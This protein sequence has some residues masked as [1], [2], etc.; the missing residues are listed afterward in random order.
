MKR[1][2]TIIG[3]LLI[4]S[5]PVTVLLYVPACNDKPT[6][7]PP[8][9][10][11]KD[12]VVWFYDANTQ[13]GVYGVHTLTGAI[14]SFT[15]PINPHYGLDVSADGTRL[16]VGD[17]N[18][19]Y[20]IDLDST[21]HTEVIPY[22]APH[23]ICVSPDGSL[24]ALLGNDVYILD[25][26]DNSPLF[27]DTSR[28][29]DG[30]FAVDSNILYCVTDPAEILRLNADDGFSISRSPVP[31][32]GTYQVVPCHSESKL[33]Y[34]SIISDCYYRIDGF[35]L[36]GDSMSF[37]TNV[38]PGWGMLDITKDGRYLVYTNSGWWLTY[39]W[40]PPMELTF[41]DIAADSIARRISTTGFVDGS[42]PQYWSAANFALTPDGRWL[43][44]ADWR[45]SLL[46]MLNLN[47][48]KIERYY[49]LGASRFIR[50]LRTQSA[51]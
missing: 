26:A 34:Y 12:Y 37:G 49:D 10:P 48:F 27:Y 2:M 8:P 29:T 40:D 33:Y 22:P 1:L 18:S 35:D 46:I 28:A 20:A 45:D 30:C 44:A 9:E 7:P 25:A 39:C 6:Q 24:I 17:G 16:Y 11:E 23:G 19:T 13:G 21:H 43:V 42:V 31:R 14:D 47:S 4:I 38:S 41:V 50:R 32:S 15:V 36:A 3:A 51:P 5:L